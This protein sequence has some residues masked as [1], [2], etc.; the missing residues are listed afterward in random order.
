[1]LKNFCATISEGF[2]PVELC[3]IEEPLLGN[4]FL[5]SGSGTIRVW[6]ELITGEIFPLTHASVVDGKNCSNLIQG[7]GFAKGDRILALVLYGEVMVQLS[8]IPLTKTIRLRVQLPAPKLAYFPILVNA[9]KSQNSL[10]LPKSSVE[11]P[12][13]VDSAL[14]QD[15]FTL[16]RLAISSL[17]NDA[18]AGNI[19]SWVT[20]LSLKESSLTASAFTFGLLP[21]FAISF[22]DAI[23]DT[24]R[25]IPVKELAIA[26]SASSTNRI[27]FRSVPTME[28]N[29][30]YQA[31]EQLAFRVL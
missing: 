13:L 18:A 28:V 25:I 27:N 30:S 26:D 15:L 22:R 17:R 12:L 8:L 11:F 14:I 4:S 20:I 2:V 24:L 19:L 21:A 23:G 1:V 10:L 3:T 16:N 6:V 29:S 5:L 7:F 9:H 31:R